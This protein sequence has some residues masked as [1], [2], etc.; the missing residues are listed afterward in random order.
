MFLFGKKA[1]LL[2]WQNVVLH[3]KTN[4]LITT[5]SQLQKMTQQQATILHKQ[6]M[7]SANL[8]ESTLKPDVFFSRLDFLIEKAQKLCQ[9]EPYLKFSGASPTAAYNEIIRK[10]SQ[11]IREFLI[12]YY[13]DTST[14][15]ECMK[16]EKGKC[17]KYLKAYDTI[18][19]YYYRMDDENKNFIE[20]KFKGK[21]GE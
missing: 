10:K 18:S 1:Y 16:T 13:S 7:D 20:A 17:N 6:I 14:K 5:E 11:A 15:A 12:R 21:I 3:D 8:V 2:K 4:K 9:L 19:I